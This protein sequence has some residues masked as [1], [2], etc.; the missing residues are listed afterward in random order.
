MSEPFFKETDRELIVDGGYISI[1]KAN[2]VLRERGTVVYG[3][4]IGRHWT[5]SQS[6]VDVNQALLINIE[7][8]EKDSA[9]KILADWTAHLEKRKEAKDFFYNDELQFLDRAKK[10]RGEK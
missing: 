9:E 6:V 5:V 7:P 10:L 4:N 3:S 1:D 8:I 2:R